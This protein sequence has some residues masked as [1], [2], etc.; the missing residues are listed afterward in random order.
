MISPQRRTQIISLGFVLLLLAAVFLALLPCLRAVSQASDNLLLQKRTLALFQSHLQSLADF[1]NQE[2]EFQQAAV[3]VSNVFV[4]LEAP[5]EFIEF[6]ET[7]AGLVGLQLFISPLS[8]PVRKGEASAFGFQL[9]LG[10]KFISAL[11]F[12]ARIE[13]SHWLMEVTALNIAEVSEKELKTGQFEGLELDD[14]VFSL[15]LQAILQN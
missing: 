10:G 8:L 9:V 15:T 12:L 2:S 11:R 4:D 13:Q 3:K 7:E 5:V 1:E 6:L 14:V